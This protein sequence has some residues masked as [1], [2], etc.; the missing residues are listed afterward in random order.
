MKKIVISVVTCTAILA[1][2]ACGKK[3]VTENNTGSAASTAITST[4]TEN[5]KKPDR[6][7]KESQLSPGSPKNEP[8]NAR[9]WEIT[10]SRTHHADD[11]HH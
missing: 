3:I 8:S 4:Q 11:H 6:V 5:G 7:N 10:T 9:F 2:V 1:L